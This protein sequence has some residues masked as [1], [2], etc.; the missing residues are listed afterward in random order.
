MS[1]ETCR[2]ERYFWDRC[3]IAASLSLSL[4]AL[5]VC[6][7][8]FA[9]CVCVCVCGTH[10]R[11]SRLVDAT[12]D[13]GF[14]CRT[15]PLNRACACEIP[16]VF[17]RKCCVETR[18]YTYI[19]YVSRTLVCARN[20]FRGFNGITSVSS[21]SCSRARMRR[22]IVIFGIF[23]RLTRRQFENKFD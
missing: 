1:R 23:G 22:D 17:V 20:I 7:R 21:C 13:V 14:S 15:H 16:S 5:D 8:L 2:D 10:A 3:H 18:P 6:V 4:L 9:T 11:F 19:R 12:H